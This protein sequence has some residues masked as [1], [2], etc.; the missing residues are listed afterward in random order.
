MVVGM[1]GDIALA[2]F[3]LTM[4]EWQALDP[5]SR[6]QLVAAMFRWADPCETPSVVLAEGSGRHG[7][8][9]GLGPPDPSP[10]TSANAGAGFDPEGS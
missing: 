8:A 10:A 4:E 3:V 9:S 7:Q 5:A 1:N 2:G 6:A